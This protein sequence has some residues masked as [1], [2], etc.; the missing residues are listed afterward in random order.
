VGGTPTGVGPIAPSRDAREFLP[1]A[2]KI[3]VKT[4]TDVYRL[5]KANEALGDLRDGIQGA[6][7]LTRWRIGL[8]SMVSLFRAQV[9][10]KYRTAV[11]QGDPK[12]CSSPCGPANE[13]RPQRAVLEERN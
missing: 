8:G 9:G 12:S 1:I 7:V 5:E 13:T 11:S 4:T 6:A 3:G 2:S 10:P